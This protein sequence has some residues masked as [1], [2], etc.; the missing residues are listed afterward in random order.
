[1]KMKG[2]GVSH[3]G[4]ILLSESEVATFHL[5]KPVK[6]GRRR[7]TEVYAKVSD[8]LA[9]GMKPSEIIKQTGIP[10]STVYRISHERRLTNGEQYGPREI[11]KIAGVIAANTDQ[12]Y[13]AVAKPS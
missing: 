13:V 6:R 2:L 7:N 5:H 9:Q 1:M 12:E 3:N 8:L 4:E 11:N 10:W